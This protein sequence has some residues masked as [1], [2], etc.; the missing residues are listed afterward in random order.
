[1]MSKPALD[2]VRRDLVRRTLSECARRIWAAAGA[3]DEQLATIPRLLG[4]TETM[5]TKSWHTAKAQPIVLKDIP[6]PS[7]TAVSM[8]NTAFVTGTNSRFLSS[9]HVWLNALAAQ[10]KE[11]G[12]MRVIVYFFDDVPKETEKSY[13]EAFPF[14]EIRRLPADKYEG[15]A[16]FWDP[17]HYAWK[18]YLLRDVVNDAAV[19]GRL[20]FY[21]DVA[22]TL[23]KMPD[24]WI[25]TAKLHGVSLLD[26]C[27]QKNRKWCHTQ[28]CD[29]LKMTEEEN[30]ALV[31]IRQG[32]NGTPYHWGGEPLEGLEVL[33][34]DIL[35]FHHPAVADLLK[36]RI[37]AIATLLAKRAFTAPSPKPITSAEP[38][39]STRATVSSAELK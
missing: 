30:Q 9:L 36:E 31:R 32:T 34:Y 22:S 26:D 39:S 4:D 21:M 37:R 6:P 17:K 11:V 38:V 5:A 10:K 25:A 29:I 35:C 8:D 12:E 23:V 15:F 7:A 3:T 27:R 19:S 33:G 1:M 13:V 18:L 28:F 14:V 20:I 2:E 24:E 16:D